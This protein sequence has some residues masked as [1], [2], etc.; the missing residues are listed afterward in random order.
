MSLHEVAALREAARELYARG[1]LLS[2][3][4]ALGGCCW[5]LLIVLCVL[6]SAADAL[7]G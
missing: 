1:K 7:L 2:G 5:G 6:Q 3:G 4:E